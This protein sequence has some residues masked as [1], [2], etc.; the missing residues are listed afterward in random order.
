MADGKRPA[1]NYESYILPHKLPP[2]EPRERHHDPLRNGPDEPFFIRTHQA[3]EIWFAQVLAEVEHARRLLARPAPYYVPESDMP[4][5][6]KHVRRAAGIFNL[7]RE[8]L[9][10]LETLDTTSFYNF[11]KHLFGASGTQS[12]RY[13]EVEWLLGLLD[14]GLLKY[15]GQKVA[16]D[17]RIAGRPIS[18][19]QAEYDSLE[20]YRDQWSQC[21]DG[22]RRRFVPGLFDALPETDAALRARMVD[23]RKNGTLRDGALRWLS[24]TAYPAPRWAAPSARHSDD[25]AKRFQQAYLAAYAGDLAM[26]RALQGTA[27]AEIARAKQEARQRIRF[28]FR[29][30]D[31]RSIAFLLQFAHEPMLSWPASFVEALLELEQAVTNWRAR[32]IAMVSRVLGGGR[33][34]TLGA[35]GSGLQYLRGTV[36][37]RVFPEIWDARSFLLSQEE[38]SGI[39]TPRQLSSY[40]FKHEKR[41]PE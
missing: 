22:R 7:I 40:G 19:N 18:P 31:R 37:K 1:M 17:H 2:V 25:F 35:T 10:L 3:F 38:A 16:L 27:P 30:R 23:I 28:F 12:F 24:R 13:R 5:I 6:V 8:H 32:H 21:W 34:S 26:M 9:P 11:R 39:Y 36:G 20:R 33:I 41:A 4:A 15:V 14:G 29:G